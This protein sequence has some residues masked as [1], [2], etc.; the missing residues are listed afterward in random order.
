MADH[1]TLQV[2]SAL[3]PVEITALQIGNPVA[4]YPL[5]VGASLPLVAIDTY[6][7]GGTATL[8]A[9]PTIG[10]LW[11][12][13]STAE[14]APMSDVFPTI[15]YNISTDTTA[16]ALPAR[17]YM[18]ICTTAPITLTLP[19]AVG[20]T[21]RYT[22]KNTAS[23]GSVTVATTAGQTIDGASTFV[24]DVRYMSIDLVSDGSNW[25]VF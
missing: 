25:A 9:A 21:A 22:V 8:I 19:T 24:L 2:G 17:D 12:R 6:A 4:Y 11:P 15:V 23:S 13:G 7:I 3:L 1:G 18:Y 20:N 5:Q 10:Q 14:V 16:A